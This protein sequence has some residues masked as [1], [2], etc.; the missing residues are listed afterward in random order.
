MNQPAQETD[1]PSVW[2][3]RAGRLGEDETAA[4]DQNLAIIG[5]LSVPSLDSVTTREEIDEL[6]RQDQPE[7]KTATRRNHVAQ[8]FAFAQRMQ[9]GDIVAL[10]L[11]SAASQIALGRVIGPYQHKEVGG[12]R[13]HS[14]AVEWIRPDTP[15]TAFA[16][17]LLHS[18]GAFMTVCQIRRNEAVSRFTTVLE[19]GTDPGATG[20]GVD[21]GTDVEEELNDG[22]IGQ[23]DIAQMAHD[24]IVARITSRYHG[25]ALAH[26]VQAV[27]EAD[28]FKTL[29]SPP[30]PDGG[31]DILA[32]R[33]ALGLGGPTLC[34]QVKSSTTPADVSIFRALQG[35]MQTFKADR[36]LLVSWGG[37]TK[38]TLQ[39][40]KQSHFQV[41]LW[42][43]DDLVQA[44]YRH[45]DQ[46]PEEIQADLP[47]K[48]IWAMVPQ[49]EDG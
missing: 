14:R 16:Q 31:V 13:R 12:Q 36:G 4:L 27:L 19:G 47:L 46:L 41:R 30:G 35:S 21:G 28:G 2:L 26:L 17:D 22:T 43:A 24:Q 38:P 7:T 10:P 49:T 40:A 45:Y 34:I 23:P 8:L 39:E 29:L 25:H 37:F 1:A 15:R 6:V 11:K 3:A 42:T 9:P 20:I 32:G 18:L 5:F 48:P 33:G 44:V